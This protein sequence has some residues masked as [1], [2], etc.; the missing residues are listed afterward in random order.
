M[1]VS[2]YSE[3]RVARSPHREN[4]HLLVEEGSPWHPIHIFIKLQFRISQT[5]WRKDLNQ[6][7]R[8]RTKQEPNDCTLWAWCRI[9]VQ[10]HQFHC[11]AI[12]SDH[13]SCKFFL[14]CPIKLYFFWPSRSRE[15][16]QA[17]TLKHQT[18]IPRTSHS[19]TPSRTT[20]YHQEFWLPAMTCLSNRYVKK[21]ITRLGWLHPSPSILTRNRRTA[22]HGSQE[23]T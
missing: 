9:P 8:S 17:K 6:P 10:L 21:Y 12:T 4:V 1:S 5:W 22:H 13:P 16:P 15:V 11:A 18:P 2:S 14:L 3:W 23:G 20:N 19:R 7:P